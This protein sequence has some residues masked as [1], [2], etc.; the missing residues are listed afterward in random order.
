MRTSLSHP[1]RIDTLQLTT[2]TGRIGITFCPGKRQI[3]AHSGDW[4]RDLDL[5][6]AAIRHWQADHLLTLI[7]ER[8]FEA[9]GVAELPQKAKA[10]GLAWH[11]MPITDLCV[12]DDS[13]ESTWHTVGPLLRAALMEGQ[14]V[15]VHCKGGLGRAGTITARL[16]L[17]LGECDD[18]DEAMRRVRAVRRGAIDEGMQENYLR[19]FLTTLRQASA[20]V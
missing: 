8:E 15:I 14:A 1:L 7:R 20:N 12:P 18:A 11:H 10:N 17:E 5:D 13:F 4:Q 3:G 19:N 16:L 2:C 6:L 9:L